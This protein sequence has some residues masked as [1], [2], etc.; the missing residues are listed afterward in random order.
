M[1]EYKALLLPVSDDLPCGEALEMEVA[2]LESRVE[3]CRARDGDEGEKEAGSRSDGWRTVRDQAAALLR[4][5]KNLRVAV[6][7]AQA[8]LRLRGWTGY[9][10]CVVFISALVDRFWAEVHPH[11]DA[12]EGNSAIDRVNALANL[13]DP[14]NVLQVLR[15]LPVV[16]SREV[17]TFTLRHLDLVAGRISQKAED[18]VPSM[19]MLEAA[20]TTGDPEQNLA[21][22]RAVREI[23]IA[24]G[25]MDQCFMSRAGE[26]LSSGAVATLEQGLKAIADFHEKFAEPEPVAA[27]EEAGG[28]T[29]AG[30]EAQPASAKGPRRGIETRAE[31]IAQLKLI[32]D[33]LKKSE[34]SSPVPLFLDRAVRT[35]ELDFTGIVSELL[36]EGTR[37]HIEWLSGTKL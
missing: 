34:P 15:T 2:E 21:C 37:A 33:F 5:T 28:E 20:W 36:P 31:A 26:R 9:A 24:L 4:R 22:K 11:L 23:R 30:T 18:T 16:Q 3:A 35:M 8:E 6:R 27:E 1:V 13:A 17:G 10:E 32:S 14:E 7:L 12:E 25:A 29:A 19:E